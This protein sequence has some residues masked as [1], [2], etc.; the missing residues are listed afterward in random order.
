MLCR[1]TSV[2]GHQGHFNGNQLFILLWLC[3]L[4][5][6]PGIHSD[7]CM[8]FLTQQLKI[9]VFCTLLRLTD[10]ICV[11]GAKPGRN[12]V[13]ILRFNCAAALGLKSIFNAGNVLLPHF[14]N[15]VAIRFIYLLNDRA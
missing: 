6:R 2:V 14:V 10:G 11:F 5:F 8:E 1:N 3:Q 4:H 7:P 13:D 15:R 12:K 9:P